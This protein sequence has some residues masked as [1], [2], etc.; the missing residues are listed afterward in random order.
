MSLTTI[1]SAFRLPTLSATRRT[2]STIPH[3]RA[4]ILFALSTLSNSRET[5]HLNKLS[6]LPRTE[7]SPNLKL[8]K[9]SEVDAYPLPSPPPTAAVPLLPRVKSSSARIWDDKALRVGQ[10]VLADQARQMIRLQQSLSRSKRREAR[11]EMLMQGE[12]LAWQQER[13][14]LRAEMRAA[15]VWIVASIG[16]ATALATWRFWPERGVVDSGDM[17]RKIATAARR[18][19]PLPAAAGTAPAGQSAGFAATVAGPAEFAVPALVA[20]PVTQA[21]AFT[22]LP[23]PVL[24]QNRQDRSWWRGFFWKQQ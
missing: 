18:A 5:Q 8:I 6:H 23:A 24:V 14:R 13:Q 7:H 9:T 22:G 2:F 4:S 10:A 17:G 20:A 16:T 11:R 12:Q 15:G 3:Q 19:M 21:A 1:P